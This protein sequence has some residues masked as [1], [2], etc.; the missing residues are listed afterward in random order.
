MQALELA[1]VPRSHAPIMRNRA[2]L[3]R[4]EDSDV[5]DRVRVPKEALNDLAI[6]VIDEAY[7][8]VL[9]CGD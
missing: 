8:V 7:A 2:N 6:A 3:I 9:M 5:S 1:Y 4:I